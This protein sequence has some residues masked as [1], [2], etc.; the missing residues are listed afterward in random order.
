MKVNLNV[1]WNRSK[2][3]MIIT[4]IFLD[5]ETEKVYSFVDELV[6]GLD[7]ERLDHEIEENLGRY[8][9]PPTK[10]EIHKYHIMEEFI[11]TLKGKRRK[12]WAMP[13][14][15]GRVS[16]DLTIWIDR[17]GITQ[18]WY[19]FH[20]KYYRNWRLSGARENG[21]EYTERACENRLASVKSVLG[22]NVVFEYAV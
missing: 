9:R 14:G 18:Q 2:W 12:N 17:M 22:L 4:H 11:W 6:T 20:A 19:N 7:N 13:Y 16:R 3:Q 15:G 8:L 21:L 10:F 5:L 1:N